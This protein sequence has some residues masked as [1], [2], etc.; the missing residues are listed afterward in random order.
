MKIL[1]TVMFA[2]M[3]NGFLQWSSC[4]LQL[5]FPSIECTLSGEIHLTRKLFSRITASSTLSFDGIDNSAVPSYL[6]ISSVAALVL[7]FC[8]SRK[9]KSSDGASLLPFNCRN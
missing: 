2:T 1:T 7:I 5:S 8:I 3:I 4:T 9:K 6:I